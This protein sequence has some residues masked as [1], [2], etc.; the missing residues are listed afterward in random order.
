MEYR[1]LGRSGLSVSAVSYGTW[2]TGARAFDEEA[3]KKCVHAALDVGITTF[4]TADVYAETRAE[5]ALGNALYR[6]PRG[7]YELCTKVYNA[8]GPGMNERGLGRKHIIEGC[9]N[10]LRRLRTDHID[11]YQAHRFDTTVPIEETI[12]AFATLVQSGKILYVGVSEWTCEQIE[13]V[14]RL[15][16]SRGVLLVSNQPQ[17]SMLWRVIEAK[18]IPVSE[19][20]GVSQMVW[21]PLA[22]GILTGKYLP[23][24]SYP[25]DSRATGGNRPRMDRWLSD[26]VLTRVRTLMEIALEAN[27]TLAQLAIS[28]VLQ[29]RNVATAIVGAS[30]PS[31]VRENAAAAEIRLDA[32]LM[33]RIDDVLHGVIESDPGKTPFD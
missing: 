33:N 19:K 11:V 13:Y 26:E 30:R 10:S 18:V 6:A 16:V 15:A 14:H 29:H 27:M 21:S 3:A 32:D 2:L 4:D 17:Y 8:V 20:L 24:H 9:D 7:S 31:Q 22:E 1:R 23:G 5:S 25:A 12:G 28:W